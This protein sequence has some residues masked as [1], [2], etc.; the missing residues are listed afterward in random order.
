MRSW[1]FRNRRRL[2]V[3]YGT[4]GRH[5]PLTEPAGSHP[6]A[7]EEDSDRA[8]LPMPRLL[9]YELI[10]FPRRSLRQAG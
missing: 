10:P 5:R 2:E 8:P 7:G 1:V 3:I 4:P 6:E 9:V